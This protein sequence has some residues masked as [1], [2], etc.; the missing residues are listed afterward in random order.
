MSSSVVGGNFGDRRGHSGDEDGVVRGMHGRR[1]QKGFEGRGRGGQRGKKFR[2][3]LR[4][5]SQIVK[6]RTKRA[7]KQ[8]YQAYRTDQKRSRG[9]GRGSGGRG[10]G[11]KH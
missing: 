2:N 7:D 3:E 1:G 4:D 9:R 11:R 10:R 6:D 8:E 5:K